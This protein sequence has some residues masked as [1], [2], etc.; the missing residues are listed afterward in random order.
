[1]F[2][3]LSPVSPFFLPSLSQVEFPRVRGFL[4]TLP[5]RMRMRRDHT[6]G[7]EAF[8]EITEQC[9]KEFEDAVST[10]RAD[11]DDKREAVETG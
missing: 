7:W 8:E 5:V 3:L 4:T 6:N 11:Q 1:M 10:R 2:A 9:A